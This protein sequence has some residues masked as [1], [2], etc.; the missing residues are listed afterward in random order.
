MKKTLLLIGAAGFLGRH[1]AN[2]FSQKNWK[3]VGIDFVP[4]G[5]APLPDLFKYFSM[6]LPDPKFEKA[7]F[8]IQPD[9]CIHSAGLASV[10]LSMENPSADYQ[11]GP[12]L[13]HYV[14]NTLREHAHDC[15]FVFLSSAAV[16][17]N[18]LSLPV[19]EKQLPSPI[20]TYGFNKWQSELMCREFS[21]IYGLSVAIVRIFSAYGQGLRQQVIWDI[22]QKASSGHIIN[23]EGTGNESRD[24]IHASDIA[25]GIEKILVNKNME[26]EIYNLA[27][28]KETTIRD[29]SRLILH[30]LGADQNKI[31][32]TNS[33]PAGKPLNWVA[34]ISHIG[35]LG[36]KPKISL[37]EGIKSYVN[38]FKKNKG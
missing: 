19:S 25:L 1:F 30:N 17:G 5:K 20:S 36:F 7:V 31:S 12:A 38:W 11:G 10:K 24:F 34:D 32:F 6:Q 4:R 14:L 18:P 21:I 33:I 9:A 28:G 16:Y 27:S 2:Y 8:E 37:E 23:L 13:T 26:I 22:C 15:R 29:L 3:V 35:Q